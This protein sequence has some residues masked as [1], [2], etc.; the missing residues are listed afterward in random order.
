MTFFFIVLPHRPMWLRAVANDPYTAKLSWQIPR[1]ARPND[2]RYRIGWKAGSNSKESYVVVNGT[3]G[4]YIFNNL[5]PYVYYYFRVQRG[6]A[7]GRY[8]YFS[9]SIWMETP[10]TSKEVIYGTFFF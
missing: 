3:K 6:T 7:S 2:T 5:H 10:E 8:G 1:D 4:Y 9:R